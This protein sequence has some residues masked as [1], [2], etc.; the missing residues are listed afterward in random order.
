MGPRS[1]FAVFHVRSLCPAKGSLTADLNL[2]DIDLGAVLDN[3]LVLIVHLGNGDD[4]AA[5]LEGMKDRLVPT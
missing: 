4:H 3:Q 1:S 2:V 5:F